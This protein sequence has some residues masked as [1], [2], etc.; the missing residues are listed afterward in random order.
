MRS[1]LPM[2]SLASE[3]FASLAGG[4]VT[5]EGDPEVEQQLGLPSLRHLTPLQRS[6]LAPRTFELKCAT[7]SWLAGCGDVLQQLGAGTTCTW[8]SA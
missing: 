7:P 5:G 6:Q 4:D 1:L 2:G 3:Q 8:S